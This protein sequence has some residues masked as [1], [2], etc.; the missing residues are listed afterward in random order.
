MLREAIE[1]TQKEK[2]VLDLYS[3]NAIKFGEF[4]LKSGLISPYYVDLRILV[5]YPFML[6]LIADLFWEKLRLLNFDV[7]AVIPYTAIPIATAISL[8]HSR[9]MIFIR[10]EVKDYGTKKLIEG[11][12]HPGQKA[13]IIDDVITTGESKVKTIKSL[14]EVGLMVEDT[15]VLVD[16]SQ[17]GPSLLA[18]KGYSCH[19]IFNINDI[20]KI[21]LSHK[22]I[23]KK[24][25]NKCL[26]FI[27]QSNKKS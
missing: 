21:L 14:E 5:S 16:R 8:R 19:T 22:K 15:V 11:E 17:G 3:I 24:L 6:E 20:F 7:L 26:R 4:K 2:L 1:L 27:K 18:K 12:Y 9:P 10:K 23:N 25:S 13:I